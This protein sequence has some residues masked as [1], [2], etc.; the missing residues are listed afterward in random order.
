MSNSVLRVG[1]GIRAFV[2]EAKLGKAGRRHYAVRYLE[3]IDPDVAALLALRAIIDGITSTRI[4]QEVAL[5]VAGKI[6]NEQKYKA[7]EEYDKKAAAYVQTKILKTSNN[8]HKAGVLSAA[9][10]VSNLNWKPWIKTEKLHLG[11]KMSEIVQEKTGFI[12]VSDILTG[13][14]G[15]H[16]IVSSTEKVKVWITKQIG[17]CEFLM[18]TWGFQL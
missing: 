17:R 8:R 6:E 2:T 18:P 14:N 16:K 4:L 7:L 13:R 10:K 5:Q 12:E 15:V 1:D 9:V 11:L 3:N